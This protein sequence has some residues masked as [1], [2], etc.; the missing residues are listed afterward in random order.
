MKKPITKILSVVLSLMLVLGSISFVAYAEDTVNWSYDSDTKT[1]YISGSGSMDNYES[2]Y[3]TP[4][5]SNILAIENVVVEDGVTAVGGYAFCG[6]ENLSSVTLADSVKTINEYAFASCPALHELSLSSNVTKIADYSFAYNG[7]SA[8]EFTL[9]A[10]VGS[11]ALHYIIKNNRSTTTNRINFETDNVTCGE[12]SVRI[13]QSGGMYAYY[14]FTPE[15]DGAFRFYSTGNHDTRGYIF[16]SNYQQIAYNDDG[17]DSTNFLISSISLEKGKTYYFGA[18]I[19]NSS[20]KGSFNVFIEPVEYTVTWKNEDGTVLETDTDAA[21]GTTPTYNSAAPTK[22]ADYDYT[23][24][25][26]GW[27]DGTNSYSL[28]DTLPAVTGNVTYTATFTATAKPKDEV[29]ITTSD[30][31]DVNLYLVDTGAEETVEFTFNTTPGEQQDTQ[32]TKTVDFDSL[33]TVGGKKKLAITVAP[34]Q[35][36]DNIG[37]VIKNAAGDVIRSYENYSVAEYCDEIV[38]GNY[39]DAIKTLALSVLDY[40]KAASA[41]FNYNTAAFT[42]DYNFGNFTFDTTDF[43]AAANG[44]NV[45]AVRYV[46][47]A[48]PSLRFEVNIPESVAVELTATTDKGYEAKFVKV[49]NDVILQ[50]TGIPAAKL[51]ETITITV[52]NGA[53]IQYT[54]LVYAYMAA[55]NSNTDVAKLGNTVGWYWQSAKA[56]FA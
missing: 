48:V 38:G 12:Y 43:T 20:L 23:Y 49:E 34:A 52:S 26:S 55:K 21:S 11:Y 30:E 4:W 17:G 13:S 9:K 46:A 27:T 28:T 3:S 47:T 56:V 7:I 19:M 45:S 35:I 29:S 14:P 54:P 39:A 41:F 32:E 36:R 10:P 18:R 33:P 51:G 53:T 50:V 44:I 37:I 24:E 5:N 16:N 31:I 25:F 2:Q 8:K 22:A 15:Y 1:L 6:A 42:D 40:G